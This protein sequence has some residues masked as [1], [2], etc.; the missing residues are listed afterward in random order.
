MKLIPS[1][2]KEML[3]HFAHWNNWRGRVR[4][5]E[6]ICYD[7]HGMFIIMPSDA[8]QY[9]TTAVKMSIPFTSDDFVR[10]SNLIELRNFGYKIKVCNLI[11]CLVSLGYFPLSASFLLGTCFKLDWTSFFPF[12][13]ECCRIFETRYSQ[14]T[15]FCTKTSSWKWC[16]PA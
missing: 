5:R 15:E 1:I 12:I 16:E 11:C 14:S 13:K 8:F 4:D 7:K 2:P 9:S 3:F 10:L 6:R